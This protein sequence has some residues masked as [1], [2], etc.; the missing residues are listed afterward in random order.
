MGSAMFVWFGGAAAGRKQWREQKKGR[1]R[2]LGGGNER[3][4]KEK[5][6][7]PLHLSSYRTGND[8]EVVYMYLTSRWVSGFGWGI[9]TSSWLVG[10][11]A[12]HKAL[13]WIGSSLY[14]S[15]S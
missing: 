8:Y 9:Y 7:H 13:G 1:E 6:Y 5:G 10:V 3:K 12:A 14:F 11:Q 4:A 2:E 15:A